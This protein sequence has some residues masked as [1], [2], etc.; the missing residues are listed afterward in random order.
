MEI[1]ITKSQRWLLAKALETFTS[2]ENLIK[3]LKDY[4]VDQDAMA[5]DLEDLIERLRASQ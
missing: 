5:E 1:E 3:F 4:D 2:E